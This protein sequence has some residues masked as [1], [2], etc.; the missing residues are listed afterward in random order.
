MGDKKRCKTNIVARDKIKVDDSLA[1]KVLVRIESKFDV[2]DTLDI[3]VRN[4]EGKIIKHQ[5]H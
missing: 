4:S 5:R 2:V 1:M 3:R